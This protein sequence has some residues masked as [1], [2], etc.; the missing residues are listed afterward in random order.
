MLGH[1]LVERVFWVGSTKQSL[2]TEQDR[3]DLESRRP[4]VLQNVQADAAEPVDVRVIDASQE[5]D[6]RWA[7]RVVV[8]EEQLE[9]EL[10]AYRTVSILSHRNC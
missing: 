8:R 7:H 4:V 5:A 2:N 3:A 9:V 6:P 10:S 1:G